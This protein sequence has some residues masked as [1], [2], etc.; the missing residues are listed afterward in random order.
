[1]M[2]PPTNHSYHQKSLEGK[3]TLTCFSDT[4]I[5]KFCKRPRPF[6]VQIHEFDLSKLLRMYA[7]LSIE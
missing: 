4:G 7:I 1:M 5:P 2:L 3:P 6:F